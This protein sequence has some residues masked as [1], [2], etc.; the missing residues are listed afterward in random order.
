MIQDALPLFKRTE[1][2]MGRI[3]SVT[4]LLLLCS[5]CA[6]AQTRVDEDKAASSALSFEYQDKC[7]NPMVESSLWLSIK[8]TA[9][10]IVSGNT[11]LVVTDDN[12]RKQVTLAAVD[13]SNS[14]DAARRMLGELVLNR[15][16]EVLINPSEVESPSVHGVVTGSGRDI[17]RALIDAGTAKSKRPKRYTISGYTACVY[18]V[19]EDEARK[20]KRGLWQHTGS[21]EKRR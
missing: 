2:L 17:N 12:K 16:V 1:V 8:A 18:T 11:I 3:A 10:K 5:I 14:D 15:Q 7:G 4:I 9:L 6:T 19:V 20:A 21:G 13:A